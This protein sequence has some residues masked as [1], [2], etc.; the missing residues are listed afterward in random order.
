[1]VGSMV[2]AACRALAL[3]ATIGRR[4]QRVRSAGACARRVVV[5][6]NGVLPACGLWAA[7]LPVAIG[8]CIA[9]CVVCASRVVWVAGRRVQQVDDHRL[10]FGDAGSGFVR[11]GIPPGAWAPFA[12]TWTWWAVRTSC[13][14][15]SGGRVDA[16]SAREQEA[17]P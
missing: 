3:V 9:P 6:G 11:H 8:H 2:G 10:Q 17:M 12:A 15:N 1:G 14:V 5:A 4:R 13:A 16:R 7:G